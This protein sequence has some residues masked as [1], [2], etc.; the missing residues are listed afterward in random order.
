MATWNT[1]YN[2]NQYNGQSMN[3][4]KAMLYGAFGQITGMF[5]GGCFGGGY[6]MGSYGMGM[7]GS[8]FSMM[9]SCGC[10]GGY[11]MY[12][13]GIPDSYVGAQCGL[14]A[15][16]VL[17][18]GIGGYISSR[19]AEKAAAQ[20]PKT[21]ADYKKEA[22]AAIDKSTNPNYKKDISI[23]ESNVTTVKTQTD[24]IKSAKKAIEGYDKQI[25]EKQKLIKTPTA[26]QNL[27][28]TEK[29]QN[30]KIDAEITA[31][32]NEKDKEQNRINAAL[33]AIKNLGGD[34]ANITNVTSIDR[35]TEIANE[36]L[37]AVQK[38]RTDAIEAKIKELKDADE[39]KK[40]SNEKI[41]S[42]KGTMK[43]SNY[44]LL[45]DDTG[46]LKDDKESAEYF[47]GAKQALYYFKNAK[48]GSK[49]QTIYAKQF[50]ALYDKLNENQ[51]NQIENGSSIYDEAKAYC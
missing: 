44:K 49:A 15:M 19:R 21:D 37:T 20:Q 39:S 30:S 7:G 8:L 50:V 25:E 47:N 10:F 36:A 3:F 16:N 35:I 46:N 13:Y 29:A 1:T 51:K 11:G 42:Y 38:A 22:E 6:G 4:G 43:N 12:G 33:T 40:K 31:L 9:G 27:T 14:T 23:A 32:K 17:F 45:F 48:N 5:G 24:I 34:L 26:G 28:D 41:D 18:Q 2:F